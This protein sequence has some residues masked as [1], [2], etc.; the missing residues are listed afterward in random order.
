MSQTTNEPGFDTG[1][2]PPRPPWWRRKLVIAPLAGYGHRCVH[3][4][5]HRRATRD[6]RD[7]AVMVMT[8]D[9]SKCALRA[10]NYITRLEILPARRL[11]HVSASELPRQ[12]GGS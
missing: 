10:E 8:V 6:S 2:L 3:I 7:V 9:H 4:A 11:A 1:T 12:G 5:V